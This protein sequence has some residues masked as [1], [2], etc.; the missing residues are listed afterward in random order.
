M[1]ESK[2]RIC[3]FVHVQP[4]PDRLPAS[5]RCAGCGLLLPVLLLRLPL[6]LLLRMLQVLR[7]LPGVVLLRVLRRNIRA[8]L[9]LADGQAQN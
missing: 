5:W 1:C 3:F 8:H 2:K 6:A 9:H 7:H 4:P